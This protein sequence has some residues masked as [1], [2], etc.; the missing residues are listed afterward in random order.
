MTDRADTQQTRAIMSAVLLLGRRLRAARPRDA[1]PISQLNALSILRRLGAMPAARLAEEMLLQPQ[2]LS[3]LIVSLE[4]D[5]LIVRTPGSEDRRTILLEI[6][7]AGREAVVYDL[8]ARQRW[9]ERA[10]E[11]LTPE[12]RLALTAASAA[13]LKL[14]QAGS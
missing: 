8:A 13:M 4:E 14:A 1:V 7:G 3:R 2:S 12:E 10:M 5:G 11:G 9:L 6:T